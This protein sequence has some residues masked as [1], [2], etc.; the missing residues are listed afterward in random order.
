MVGTL[1]RYHSNLQMDIERENQEDGIMRDNNTDNE[2]NMDT[3]QNENTSSD[4]RDQYEAQRSC[5]VSRQ[6]EI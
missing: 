2:Q 1:D 3:N 4:H 5:A 6:C